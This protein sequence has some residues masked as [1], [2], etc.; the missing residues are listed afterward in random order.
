MSNFVPDF[1][2]APK[3]TEFIF[4]TDPHPLL[5]IHEIIRPT[6][7]VFLSTPMSFLSSLSSEMYFHKL[8]SHKLDPV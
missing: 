3:L 7:I 1:L 8:C 6:L 4:R 2:S 5:L